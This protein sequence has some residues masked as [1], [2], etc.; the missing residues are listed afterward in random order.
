VRPAAFGDTL[1]WLSM[2]S[3]PVGPNCMASA[4]GETLPR[5]RRAALPCGDTLQHLEENMDE[6]RNDGGAGPALAAHSKDAAAP[7]PNPA[8]NKTGSSEPSGGVSE[9][10]SRL[11]EQ[12]REAAGRLGSSVSE[13]AGSARQTL[14]EQ[15]GRAV[16]QAGVFVREQ[17]LMALAVTGVVCLAMGIL[18]GRR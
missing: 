17:P 5:R 14:S 18:L 11:S 4:Y 8:S 13:A 10:V 7:G 2:Q 12:A 9:T 16:N 3:L 1:L 6:N 15:G